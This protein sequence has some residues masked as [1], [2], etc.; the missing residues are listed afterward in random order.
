V[1]VKFSQTEL[2]EKERLRE[3]LKFI[4]STARKSHSGNAYV[5]QLKS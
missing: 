5:A 1:R 4:E 2:P 3:F